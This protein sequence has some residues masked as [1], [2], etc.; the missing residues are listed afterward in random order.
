[1]KQFRKIWL[2]LLCGI[3]MLLAH[4]ARAD[5]ITGGEMHYSFIGVQGENLVY[6]V[7]VKLLMRC[8]SGRQFPNPIRIS[9]FDK[10]S[11]G[12]VQ[13]ISVPLGGQTTINL[14]N[15]DP[16]ISNPPTVCY[17][18]ATYTF[19]VF[20]PRNSG[21]YVVTAQVNFRINGLSNLM[22]G[23][24][25][26]G[27]T[28]TA[29]LPAGVQQGDA[30]ENNSAAFSGSDLVVVCANSPFT[31]SFAADDKDGDKLRYSFCAAYQTGTSGGGM[32]NSPPNP[33]PYPTVPYGQG[34]SGN[35]PLG[36][37][38]TINPE[39]GLIE[40]IA[41]G[42]GY[43]VITV[44]VE[45]IRNGIVIATQRKDIQL[46]ITGCTI[47]AALLKPEYQL[48]GDSD[49]LLVENQSASPLIKSYL[50]DLTDRE[51]KVVATSQ[52]PVFN[53]RLKDTGM[54]RIRLNTN[55]GL[56]CPDS[57]SAPVRYYPGFKPAFNFTGLCFG[58]TTRFTDHSSGRYGT[59][60]SRSWFLGEPGNPANASQLASPSIVYQSEGN[61][62]VSL[63]VENSNGC[64]DSV[65]TALTISKEPP[66]QFAFR[67]TL[68][69]LPD[70]LQLRA[71]GE[72]TFT[73]DAAPGLISGSTTATPR[74]SPSLTSFFKV[75]QR[76][77]GCIGT[78]SVRVRVA[79]AV[80]LQTMG[81]TTI[82]AGDSLVLRAG[83]NGNL[84]H[85]T[86]AA[87]LA[88]A[89]AASPAARP[90]ASTIYRVV[91]SISK[92]SASAEIRVTTVA[93]PQA[94]AGPDKIICF[95]HS[96]Q[97]NST[98][99]GNRF[100]WLP[101]GTLNNPGLHSP[102]ATPLQTTAYVLKVYDQ[103]GCPK[104]GID[105]VVVQV[106]PPIELTLNGDTSVVVGQVLQLN[107]GGASRYLWLPSTG[108]SSDTVP[109]PAAT[110]N[111]PSEML[112]YTLIGYNDAGCRDSLTVRI[113]VFSGT[114][115]IYVPTAFTPNGDGL[116]ET[117]KPTLAGMMK[118]DYF[119]IFNRFG[120]MVYSTGSPY[121][122]W[123]GKVKGQKQSSGLF[124]WMVQA[125]DYE[126]KSVKAKGTTMLIK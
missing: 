61:K 102:V 48:C 21:G 52:D 121:D 19:D 69:C 99:K 26:I 113:R 3:L 72:G 106:E 36:D 126:G 22:P 86:P 77:D 42:I 12:R 76:L 65:T 78:D 17:E 32:N 124:I 30:S 25:S 62:Q 14:N 60:I 6:S 40:G 104:P 118:L 111:Q 47:A 83:G 84:Y 107:G 81:D 46:N 55:S 122:A 103:Q 39:T 75:T 4:N 15:N 44:C 96:V 57:A 66:L 16:C 110:F 45:E 43:Y 123:D 117:L 8:N 125:V 20:V 120:E 49:L 37:R 5:H 24:S 109:N 27:A 58:G 93:Y 119:K 90:P 2:W 63:R 94:N 105:T 95:G 18:V 80:L 31:Y 89:S 10:V 67:D 79:P 56:T 88:D 108:L 92:C 28:Y 115:V 11:N 91:S 73:W 98:V 38:V 74:V 1:M 9:I 51:G 68:I 71:F 97:L 13:D 34:F 116:N 7:T 33:P 23:S 50:W 41:P 54:F 35:S 82:C 114:P 100:E 85:W 70:T 87:G 101:A 53:Y 112:V 59:V 29:D 64:R